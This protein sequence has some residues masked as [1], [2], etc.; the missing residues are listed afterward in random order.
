MSKLWTEEQ[1]NCPVCLD[2]PS[3]PVTIPCGHSYC[4]ACIADFWSTEKTKK[5]SPGVYSCP[6]CRQ[7]F[8]PQPPLNRNTMLSEA[9]EQLRKGNKLSSGARE[10]IRRA[11][12]ASVRAND[13]AKPG[14]NG[15][16]SSAAAVA[17]PCDQCPDGGR[18]AAKTCLVCMA[19]FCEAHLKPHRTNAKLKGHELIAPTGNLAEKM[20]PQHKYLQEFY[21]KPCQMYVCWLCTSNQHKGHES[22]STQAQRTEKQKEVEVA[23][24]QNQQRLQE[25]QKELK[26]MK[27]VLESV[28]RSSEKAQAEVETVL[29][30]LQRSVQRLQDLVGEVML[31][32]GQ[33]KLSEAQDVV[34]KLQAEV[35]LMKRRETDMRD[36]IRCQDNIYFLQ[37]CEALVCPVEEGDLGSVCVNPDAS[38]D[39]V[40]CTVLE[41]RQRVEEMC[42]LELNNINRTGV[43]THTH[44]TAHDEPRMPGTVTNQELG[45]HPDLDRDNRDKQMK[46]T[47]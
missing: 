15:R 45:P 18:E 25:R 9:M 31:S 17:V 29:S 37:N 42:N 34:Q 12:G 35:R 11:Q 32:T 43:D 24:T 47:A 44:V 7:T 19:S 27:K 8:S 46:M 33:E 14:A 22:V 3:D 41:L 10:T 38:F 13:T 39:P 20:C 6:E 26:D 21:C 36:L 1:F 30:E 2:L 4:M 16:L 40:R 23:Q 28:T 5:K